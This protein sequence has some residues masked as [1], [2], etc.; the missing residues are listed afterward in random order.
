MST[1]CNLDEEQM[2][3]LSVLTAL[4]TL[5]IPANGTMGEVL[6]PSP[7]S[8]ASSTIQARN[9]APQ[10]VHITVQSWAISGQGHATTEI[11]LHGFYVAHLI[12]GH[13]L[14]TIDGKT[15]EHLPGDYWSVA[16]GEA[17]QVKVL[18]EGAVLETIV[19]AKQ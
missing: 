11:P 13:I 12:S 18:N 6:S 17:L 7:V 19:V 16:P 14:G 15:T 3:P 5:A 10:A 1:C 9:G 8:E 2:K 4:I